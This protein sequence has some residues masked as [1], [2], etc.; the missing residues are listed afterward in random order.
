MGSSVRIAWTDG[1]TEKQV[2]AALDK[3]D[4][5]HFDAMT[6]YHGR[7]IRKGDDGKHYCYEGSIGCARHWSKALVTQAA[8]MHAA[9]NGIANYVPVLG[10]WNEVE[11]GMNQQLFNGFSVFCGS[12]EVAADG[13]ILG[14]ATEFA[15]PAGNIVRH[16]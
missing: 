8:I 7:T 11:W 9:N 4:S 1:P 13:T 5:S 3:Y 16:T 6:D 14:V 12:L 15:A 10:K 2:M